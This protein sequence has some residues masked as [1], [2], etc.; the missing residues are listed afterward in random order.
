MPPLFAGVGKSSDR[1][2]QGF[3]VWMQNWQLWISFWWRRMNGCQSILCSSLL[4]ITYYARSSNKCLLLVLVAF[5]TSLIRWVK[6]Q[7]YIKL[8]WLE[9]WNVVPVLRN[10]AFLCA[11]HGV[12]VV[13]C[14][15][16]A[17]ASTETS[18]DSVV[19][20]GGLHP[21][22]TPQHSPQAPS[23]AADELVVSLT[24]IQ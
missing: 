18:S 11:N 7:I 5:E 13:V 12:L 17:L 19:S 10:L 22:A 16:A 9:K 21:Q 24:E 8:A 2:H 20:G 4:K 3:W 15:Q 14:V 6:L 23:P 1:I